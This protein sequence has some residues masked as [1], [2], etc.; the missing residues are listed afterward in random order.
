MTSCTSRATLASQLTRASLRPAL[1]AASRPH[2]LACQVQ[3]SS[4]SHKNPNIKTSAQ[5]GFFEVHFEMRVTPCL[6]NPFPPPFPLSPFPTCALAGAPPRASA[7]PSEAAA[8][9]SP[10]PRAKEAARPSPQSRPQTT[11]SEATSWSETNRRT[12]AEAAASAVLSKRN[13]TSSRMCQLEKWCLK[14]LFCLQSWSLQIGCLAARRFHTHPCP[15]TAVLWPLCSDVSVQF[16][17]RGTHE[18][19]GIHGLPGCSGNLSSRRK[20][21]TAGRAC[22][23]VLKGVQ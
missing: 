3:R 11:R 15:S 8:T 10:P 2:C 16:V 1:L 6:R 22:A 23:S 19:H 4:A 20:R 13:M 17:G 18:L 21:S 14:V 7:A 12:S 5:L 9:A